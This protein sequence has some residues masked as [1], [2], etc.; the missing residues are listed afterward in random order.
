MNLKSYIIENVD[1]FN[2]NV[3][4][5]KIPKQKWFYRIALL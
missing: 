1:N 4:Q 3:K 5:K 2:T